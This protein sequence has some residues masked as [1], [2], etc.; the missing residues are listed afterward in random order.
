VAKDP[1]IAAH[2][3]WLGYVQP[4]GLLVSAP[5]LVNAQAFLNRNIIPDHQRFLE[6][7]APIGITGLAD[8]VTAVTDLPGLLREVFGW[9]VRDLLGAPGAD[10]VPDSL[11]VALPE[12]GETLRPTYAVREFVPG[13]NGTAPWL[14]LIEVVPTG[15][16]FDESAESDRHRWQASPQVR[17]ERLLHE[18][19]VAI[20]LL[21]NGTQLRLVYR[22]RGETSGYATFDVQS[23]SEVTGRPIFAALHM[24]LEADRL[25]VGSEKLR[26][27]A[28]L[29]ESRKYQSLVSTQLSE[30]VLA[31]LYELLRGFQAAD[32]RRRGE[33][34]GAVLREDPN[35]VYAGLLTVLM[36]LVFTLYA[37]DRGLFPT[38]PVYVNH[39]SVTGLFERL[40]E[41]AGRYPDTMDQRFGAWAQLLTLFRLVHDGG[42]HGTFHLPP[43]HGHLFNPDRYNFLEGRP[44]TVGRVL[45]DRIDPP[46]ISDGVVYRVLEKLMV[47]DGERLSY[48]TLAVAE[49]GSVY[50]TIMGFSLERAVG[51]SIA[52]K[53][54]KPHGA[55]ATINLDELLTEAPAARAKWLQERS[56]QTVTGQALNSLQAA[57]SPEA[58]TAALGNK[59]A[60]EAT[61][62]IVP[63]GAMILQPSGERRRSG[64]HYTP[65]SL[66]EPIVRT[67]IRPVLDR[68][69][70][71]PTPEQILDLK[72][73]DPAMGSGAFLVEACRQLGDA[74]VE[75]WHAHNCVPRVP[76]DE[77]EVLHAR[78]LVAQRCLYGVD[79]NPLATDLAKL[80]IWLTTLARDHPFTFLDHALC[81]G[82]S[83]VGLTPQQLTSFHWQSQAQTV[84]SGP[85]VEQRLRQGAELRTLIRTA[86]EDSP[87]D[88]LR[89]LLRD[90]D[91]AIDDLRLIGDLILVAFFQGDKPKVREAARRELST[92]VRDW[93]A[94]HQGFNE[95][96]GLADELRE[97]V[98][99][100]VPFHWHIEFPEVFTRNNPG[101]DAIVGNPP[102]LGGTRISNVFGMRYFDYLGDCF[103]PA[104]HHC[105]LVAYFF[106]RAFDL[107]RSNCPF[108]LLA[109]KTISQGDTRAGGLG[110]ICVHGGDIY[111][112]I[113]RRRWPGQANVRVSVVHLFKGVSRD[114]RYLDG[115][116]VDTITAFLL[117]RG[118]SEDPIRL[119]ENDGRF[120]LGC[121]IYGQGFLFAADDPGASPIAEMHRL[122]ERNPRLSERIW[123]YLG[124]D[125]I[126]Q[127]PTL[128]PRRW[129]IYLSDLEQES[130]LDAWPELKQIVH[131][132]VKPERDRLGD[133]PNN[134][135]LK[136]RWWAYQA[137][138]PALY[139]KLKT[140]ERVLVSSQTSKW[141]AFVFAPTR[142]IFS[143]KVNVFVF[144]DWAAFSILQSRVHEE[145]ASFFG[146][147]MGA[148]PV[149]TASDCFQNFPFPSN[150]G[151]S[152]ALNTA[153]E[154]YYKTRARIM[155]RLGL[156]PTSL[157]NCLHDPEESSSDIMTLRELADSMD[158]AVFDAYEWPDLRPT[159]EFLP[160][161]DEGEDL[162]DEENG[163]TTTG[164]KKS[165]RYRWPDNFGD[166]VLARLLDLN[167]RRAER[168]RLLGITGD[169]VAAT[170]SGR[171]RRGRPASSDTLPFHG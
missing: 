92:K 107:L 1:E 32:D 61:P 85:L 143:Q 140:M 49:I 38:A 95:L 121:K 63:T 15:I 112:A 88:E 26:L 101:F 48:R 84:F 106:R 98:R 23:M 24:L 29:A 97:G 123:P 111:S 12:Y 132:R 36:R 93:L 68:L 77:D 4:V 99:P 41:D 55:P 74:L 169:P 10:P 165:R 70:S 25:F 158:R 164:P 153:G 137:H 120:S 11:E 94:T 102:F 154:A 35:H 163:E 166:E 34:L 18:D 87:E 136:R 62:S 76:P 141:L 78:R 45:G 81:H 159:C 7:V 105:D 116:P 151:S 39:Y 6:W 47:L 9:E 146:G 133:N 110:W 46:M 91:N 117:S 161:R 168:E 160:D 19:Q 51:R 31:A 17:F 144:E 138:R 58:I 103:P 149:Y 59:V 30:Q 100:I 127:D 162:E 142:M 124:G 89:A 104:G 2:Q 90:V 152:A 60:R 40:R 54:T 33:L 42:S 28:I 157:Y 86:R 5:A 129:V 145:W 72:V 150:W 8:P 139:E 148:T 83:L 22:P 113:R 52:V 69:G 119:S 65:E 50:Q 128:V 43:R 16:D 109:T 75:A 130:E 147:S 118:G 156:G 114:Q 66:T 80:S 67:A 155:T 44:W 115:T 27:P 79:K 125:E 14:M 64:S 134:L 56:G 13:A 167:R 126:N 20:G 3:Q 73:C 21:S 122:I 131:D 108:G 82:D 171:G 135:P 170:K 57:A 96:R 53:P 71:T 37:E